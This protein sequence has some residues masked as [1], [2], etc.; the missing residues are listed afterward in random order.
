MCRKNFVIVGNDSYIASGLDK[1]LANYDVTCLNYL[2]WEMNINLLREADCIIN[3]SISPE[4]SKIVFD[5]DDVIDV[6]IAKSISG[7]KPRFIFI[8]SRKVYGISNECLIYNE[9]SPV[10]KNDIYSI[11]KI[12]TERAL[13]NILGDKL[14]ILRP[15]NIIGEPVLRENYNTFIGWICR[16]YKSKGYVETTIN[17][18]IYK[19]FI[20]KEYLHKNIVYLM[21]HDCRGIYNISAGFG[22]TIKYLLD[23][24]VG[25]KVLYKGDEQKVKD[26]FIVDNTKIKELTGIEFS[27]KDID[28]AL[29]IYTE[30][31][32]FI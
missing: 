1:Y 21:S 15:T 10:I 30:K 22:I 25:E 27:I 3:F 26:Q 16:N 32:K 17:S 28:D 11:N 8:S 18:N 14:V 24:Y 23:G 31:L 29:K 20:T 7:Y 6:K 4:S 9:T 13:Q 5:T 2:N 19:D 12:N